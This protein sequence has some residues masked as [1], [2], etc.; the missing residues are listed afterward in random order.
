MLAT[1]YTVKFRHIIL[2]RQRPCTA[3]AGAHVETGVKVHVTDDVADKAASGGCVP[4]LVE[5]LYFALM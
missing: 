4:R 1:V 2:E 3:L 5:T